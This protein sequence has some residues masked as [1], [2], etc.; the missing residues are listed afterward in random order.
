MI[1]R[2]HPLLRA[3]LYALFLAPL[4]IFAGRGAATPQRAAPNN[5]SIESNDLSKWKKFA[6]RSGWTIRYPSNWRIRS[7]KGCLDPTERGVFVD[8]YDPSRNE[9]I[10][11]ESFLRRPLNE[12]NDDWLVDLSHKSVLNP[13]VGEAW[14]DFNGMRALSVINANT[15]STESQ[16]IYVTNG[17]VAVAIRIN[18]AMT[19]K[20][21]YQR[22][23]STFKFSAH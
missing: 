11:I 9:I 22:V 20:P 23:L 1:D 10:F 14:V 13:R 17:V 4:L 12:T 2:R 3:V 8:I 21:V 5:E 18:R 15:D 16:N 19:S 6:S 7:C